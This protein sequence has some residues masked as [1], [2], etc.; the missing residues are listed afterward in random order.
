[1]RTYCVQIDDSIV[2]IINA[3]LTRNKATL[4]MMSI[5]PAIQVPIIQEGSTANDGKRAGGAVKN[6][7]YHQSLKR[8]Q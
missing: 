2:R 3:I 4:P 1:M 5:N 6:M 8:I 7:L